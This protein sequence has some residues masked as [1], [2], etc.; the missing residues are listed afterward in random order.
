MKDKVIYVVV[1]LLVI[2]TLYLGYTAY[3][4]NKRIFATENGIGQIVNFINQ[5]IELAK[6]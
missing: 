6:Q 2:A 4:L 3:S 1:S 5:Q